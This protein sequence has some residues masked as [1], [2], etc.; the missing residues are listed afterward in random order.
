MGSLVCRGSWGCWGC[1]VLG[2]VTNEEPILLFLHPTQ[3]FGH[4]EDGTRL[5][6]QGAEA[7]IQLKFGG[8]P[9]QQRLLLCHVVNEA[10]RPGG[11]ME[12]GVQ[13]VV[14]VRQALALFLSAV[15]GF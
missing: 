10:Q 14:Q 6:H 15:R 8:H 11:V 5:G 13:A 1:R 4:Y 12:A 7:G 9:G 2:W 3:E